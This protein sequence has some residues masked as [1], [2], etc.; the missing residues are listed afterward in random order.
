MKKI[1]LRT[2]AFDQIRI[3]ILL[4]IIINLGTLIYT[5]VKGKTDIQSYINNELSTRIWLVILSIL[6]FFSTFLTDIIEKRENIDIPDI[7]EV[8]ITLFI[9]AGIL[10]ST[11]FNLYYRFFWWDDLLHAISV[12]ITSSIGFLLLI[13]LNNKYGLKFNPLLISIFTFSFSLAIGVFWEILEFTS[14]A[15][16]GSNHQRWNVDSSSILIGKSYQG[17]GLRD[18]MSDLIVTFVSA[19]IMAVFFY[20]IYKYHKAFISKKM[21]KVIKDKVVVR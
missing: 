20:F 18:T 21:S 16:I 19:I 7:L 17:Y 2:I 10:L 6:V 3:L 1:N 15:L 11:Q 4:A 13:K 9:Y 5:L 12:L 14:D 8:I